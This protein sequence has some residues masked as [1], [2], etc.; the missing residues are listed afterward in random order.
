MELLVL[1]VIAVLCI[2]AIFVKNPKLRIV[3]VLSLVTVVLVREFSIEAY[4]SSLLSQRAEDGLWTEQYKD[5]AIAV[6]DYC[7]STSI[8]VIASLILL[9]LLC[10]RAFSQQ[11]KKLGLK[12]NATLSNR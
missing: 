3:A 12:Q 11:E 7:K 9:V 10:I 5:G 8:F 4:V 6:L 2:I 1:I